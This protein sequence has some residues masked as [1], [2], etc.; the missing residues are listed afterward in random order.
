MVINMIKI[1]DNAR[2]ELCEKLSIDEA[3]LTFLGGGREDSDGTVFTFIED[4]KKKVLKILAFPEA[5]K[6]KLQHLILRIKYANY[7][8]ENGIRIAYPLRNTNGNLY[9]TSLDHNHYYAAYLMDYC[10][11]KNPE[12]SELTNELVYQWGKLTGKSHLIT[13]SF[14]EKIEESKL[15][16]EEELNFF[17][18]WC[19][20]AE[21]KA[22]WKHMNE[23]LKSFHRCEDNYGFIHNDNHQ[24]N[25]LVLG[26]DITLIDFD[27]SCR[28]FFVQDIITPAQGIMF[29][30][31]GGMISPIKE[32]ERLKSFFD[33]F[34]NGYET[35]HHLSD[36]WYEQIP[37]FLNYRRMLLFTC[38]Q[39]WLN[40]EP[41]LK[42]NFKGNILNPPTFHL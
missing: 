31:T 22:A 17:T 38:M 5:E 13:K 32:E 42:K 12:S 8:G 35:E 40:T 23:V 29:D 7:L 11:G 18:N 19:K 28:Q 33:S 4:S 10:D 6:D 41:E 21:I 1:T 24:R 2:K 25:I 37:L 27:C 36:F 9:E 26:H 3:T 30:I 20:D 14:R 34:I 39:D 16:H 15:G